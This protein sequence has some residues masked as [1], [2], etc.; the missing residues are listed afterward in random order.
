MKLGPFSNRLNTNHPQD[1]LFSYFQSKE[2]RQLGKCSNRRSKRQY[3]YLLKVKSSS[4]QTISIWTRQNRR[5]ITSNSSLTTTSWTIVVIA[6]CHT[7]VNANKIV[8][9]VISINE[10]VWGSIW[11]SKT[12]I[13]PV[14][15][16]QTIKLYWS[17][18]QFISKLTTQSTSK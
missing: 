6:A 15:M 17:E 1:Q 18:N 8:L 16:I 4:W 5:H 9:V 2:N 10:I 12:P 7:A 3:N 14:L 11:E 13:I